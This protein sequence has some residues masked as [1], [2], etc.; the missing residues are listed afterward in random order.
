MPTLF[1]EDRMDINY[2]NGM[3]CALCLNVLQSEIVI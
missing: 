3:A 2:L 1:Q